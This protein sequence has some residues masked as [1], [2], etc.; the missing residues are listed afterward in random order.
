[1]RTTFLFFFSLIVCTWTFAQTTFAARQNIDPDTGIKPYIIASGDLDSDTTIDIVIGTYDWDF[2]IN[3]DYIK[4]YKND[5]NGNFTLQTVV[6]NSSSL[7]LISWIQIAD[8][9]GV[10]GNDIIATSY[11]DDKLVWFANDGVGGFGTEQAIGGSIDGAGIFEIVD[12]NNDG[13]LDI[14]INAFDGDKISWYEGDGAGNFGSEQVIVPSIVEPGP[15]SFSD[16][17]KDGD[18]D[19]LVGYNDTVTSGTLEI[20]YNQ[21]IESGTMTVSWIK[22]AVTVDSGNAYLISAA[23]ADVNDDGS[24]DIVKSDNSSG[25]VAW[26]N[27]IKNGASAETLISD[28]TIIDRPAVVMVADLD[29]DTYNDVILTD[30]GTID[31]AL[32]WF[33]STDDGN[34]NADAL[35]DNNN[36]QLYGITIADFDNDGDMDIASTGWQS[37]T[38]DWYEN[39]LELLD[40]N[41]YAPYSLSIYPNPTSEKI[42]IKSSIEKS[43]KISVYDML[44]KKIMEQSLNVNIPL[45]VSALHRGVYF[46]TFKD[47]NSTLKFVKE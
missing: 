21:F 43:F 16:F 40:T 7:L 9:D 19:F 11:N 30:G 33:E 10:N 46:I 17:D 12:I 27:K 23:F 37:S 4:W 34:L 22:D 41:D 31:D 44:G 28:D 29:N 3:G 26:Y 39:Q 35:I 32:I 5:G 2:G 8:I 25:D 14:C 13:D 15:L 24:M 1:M 36:F 18:L 45:D 38:L 20:Y 6:S 47:H 42:F